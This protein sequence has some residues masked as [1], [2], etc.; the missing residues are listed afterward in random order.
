ML[1]Y[2]FSKIG[3]NHNHSILFGMIYCMLLRLGV[4]GE[5]EEG[6]IGPGIP[7]DDAKHGCPVV[8]DGHFILLVINGS[9]G[10]LGKYCCTHSLINQQVGLSK[11]LS[12]LSCESILR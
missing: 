12:W 8:R 11:F 1:S 5:H 6:S 10:L 4:A 2:L 3:V 9:N 7:Q